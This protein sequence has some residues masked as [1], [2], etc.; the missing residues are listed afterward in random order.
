[1]TSQDPL[2]PRLGPGSFAPHGAQPTI[3]SGAH[4]APSHSTQWQG[5][6]QQDDRAARLASLGNL[7]GR[8]GLLAGAL[9][10]L[11]G[12]ICGDIIID[13]DNLG[14]ESELV[15]RVSV[16]VWTAIVGAALGFMLLAWDG[17][18]SSMRKKVAADGLRGACVGAVGG[19]VS[20]YVGQIVYG[21]MLPSATDANFMTRAIAA[22]AVAW[23]IFGLGLGGGLAYRVN[24]RKATHGLV[25][26]AAGGFVGGAIFQ[27]LDFATPFIGLD[28]IIRVIG[29][30]ITGAGIGVGIKLIERW[31]RTSWLTILNGPLKGKE[32]ILY[33]TSTTVG[34]DH[35]CDVVLIRDSRAAPQ[36]AIISCDQQRTSVR[37]AGSQVLVNGI[38]VSSQDL[39]DGDRVLVG[40]TVFEYHLHERRSPVSRSESGSSPAQSATEPPDSSMQV[41]F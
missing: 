12:S 32:I 41:D 26:G 3:R 4:S 20:G 5:P 14:Y 21:S 33:S 24:A 7:P 25:G 38:D 39:F 28:P 15:L 23:A 2:P 18:T 10:G 30:T 13:P 16:G 37:A 19:F 17:L 6:P 34:A 9:G 40:Q 8:S 11:V 27:L 35:R 22:R 36:H 31:R 29:T 1:M